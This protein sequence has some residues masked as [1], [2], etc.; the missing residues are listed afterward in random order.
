MAD[1]PYKTFKARW[2]INTVTDEFW[3]TISSKSLKTAVQ[4][5]PLTNILRAKRHDFI[6][7]K[8]GPKSF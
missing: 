2:A 1:I 3:V 4:I 5:R 6:S 8:E 7:P